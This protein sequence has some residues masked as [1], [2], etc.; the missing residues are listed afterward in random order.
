MGNGQTIKSPEGT[1]HPAP[2]N[3]EDAKA[4]EATAEKGDANDQPSSTT[5][6]SDD[7]VVGPKDR[8]ASER[9][10]IDQ[11]IAQNPHLSSGLPYLTLKEIGE[12]FEI[13]KRD[14]DKNVG[15]VQPL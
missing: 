12:N 14:V 4:Q 1:L 8:I 7:V 6:N 13:M 15:Y 9:L 10:N 2:S 3:N 11:I 5:K